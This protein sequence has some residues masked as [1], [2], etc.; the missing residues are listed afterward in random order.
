MYE[1]MTT[2]MHAVIRITISPCP[3]QHANS[4]KIAQLRANKCIKKKKRKNFHPSSLSEEMR[5]EHA[6]GSVCEVNSTRPLF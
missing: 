5:C 2:H 1:Y 4:C 6:T 3:D